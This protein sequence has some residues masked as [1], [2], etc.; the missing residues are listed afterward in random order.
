MYPLST[1]PGCEDSVE[2][3]EG[4]DS[5]DHGAS[6]ASLKKW[7]R[8]SPY[9]YQDHRDVLCLFPSPTQARG[10]YLK[11]SVLWCQKIFRAAILSTFCDS[12]SQTR[13]TKFDGWCFSSGKPCGRDTR[14]R[15]GWSEG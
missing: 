7:G 11:Y 4:R 6:R 2:G 5:G 10:A 14:A 3:F 12:N 13:R 8:M 15:Q 9:A 1:R